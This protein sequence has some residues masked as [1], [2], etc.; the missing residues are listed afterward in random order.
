MPTILVANR[1]LTWLAWDS[2]NFVIVATDADHLSVVLSG[3]LSAFL[4]CS[5][6]SRAIGSSVNGDNSVDGQP[7]RLHLSHDPSDTFGSPD[8]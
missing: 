5:S 2:D 7:P 3:G 8:G 1:S 6:D 4:R